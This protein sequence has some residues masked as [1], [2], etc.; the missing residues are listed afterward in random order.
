MSAVYK[1]R[2]STVELWFTVERRGGC[3]DVGASYLSKATF[4][5]TLSLS[6]AFCTLEKLELSKRQV[7]GMGYDKVSL[8][9]KLSR[10]CTLG[11]LQTMQAPRPVSSRCMAWV[12]VY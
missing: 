3:G 4:I 6:K 5:A 12:W 11:T 8:Q 1:G 2:W 7:K 10:S 9:I